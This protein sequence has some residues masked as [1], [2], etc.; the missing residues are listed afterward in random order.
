MQL[1]AALDEQSLVGDILD[2]RLGEGEVLRD[3][4]APA[5]Q[6]GGQQL[7]KLGGEGAAGADGLQQA[8]VEVAPEDGGDLK[9]VPGWG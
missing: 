6:L 1:A 4:G 8:P 3:G 9:D 2:E 5:N 7:V